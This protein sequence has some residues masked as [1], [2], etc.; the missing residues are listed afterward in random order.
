MIEPDNKELSV[1][2]QCELVGLNRSVYYHKWQTKV[3]ERR[4]EMVALLLKV[5]EDHPYF[6]RPRLFQTLLKSGFKVSS[7]QVKKM[8]EEEK[9]RALIPF[10]KLTRSKKEHKKYPY[11]L[12]GLKINN[13]NQ[14]WATDITYLKLGKGYVYLMA[15]I[16]LYSRKI[17]SWGLSN[18]QDTGWCLRILS[19]AL[20]NY[21][22]PEIFNT[23]QGSQYTSNAFTALLT[24]NDI[25]ISMDGVG[26]VLDNVFIERF[27]RS[28]KYEDF[29][30]RDYKTLK[31]LKT[32]TRDYIKF[33]NERRIHQSLDYD[34]PNEIYF[35]RASTRFARPKVIIPDFSWMAS[36]GGMEKIPM[37]K[38]VE[39]F[40]SGISRREHLKAA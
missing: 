33:Y 11:L 15:I 31:E 38:C 39:I 10:R 17:L 32:G 2:R 5:H 13:P 4:D 26:R 40:K 35:S 25:K 7:Y 19:D 23:D 6:G 20:E 29:Y 21:G 14:V 16:D 3:I 34:I 24:S 18:T 36:S 27:W 28:V 8:M 12:H 9:I 37:E 30:I 1:R 22:K